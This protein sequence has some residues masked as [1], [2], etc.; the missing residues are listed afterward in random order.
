MSCLYKNMRQKTVVFYDFLAVIF[1][2]S[3][4]YFVKNSLFHASDFI[5]VFCDY[6]HNESNS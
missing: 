1:V 2:I 4:S 5:Y 3:E 6:L